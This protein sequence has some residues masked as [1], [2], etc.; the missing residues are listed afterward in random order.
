[1]GRV[2]TDD[3]SSAFFSPLHSLT[4]L[5]WF[6]R[7][8]AWQAEVKVGLLVQSLTEEAVSGAAS[9]LH[10]DAPNMTRRPRWSGQRLRY[11]GYVLRLSESVQ[12]WWVKLQADTAEVLSV[13]VKLGSGGWCS[14]LLC[15]DFSNYFSCC[16]L[17]MFGSNGKCNCWS[18]S[19]Y[20]VLM[21]GMK[22]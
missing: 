7:V 14:A 20:L 8:Q 22:W 12:T 9:V 13:H 21:L 18:H 4:F 1:M 6:K 5:R 16:M 17:L 3:N 15:S 19:F 11:G 2:S 10:L